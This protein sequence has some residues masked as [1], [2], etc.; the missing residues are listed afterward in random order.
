M[1]IEVVSV[2]VV[3]LVWVL[4]LVLLLV[5]LLLVLVVLSMASWIELSNISS[6]SWLSSEENAGLSMEIG[7]LS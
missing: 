4:I 5:V 6:K 3:I 1:G 7:Y 2:E